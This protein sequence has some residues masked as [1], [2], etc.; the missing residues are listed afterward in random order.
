MLRCYHSCWC[1]HNTPLTLHDL[2]ALPS[3][4][5]RHILLPQEFKPKGYSPATMVAPN[6]L[7]GLLSYVDSQ[8]K[9]IYPVVGKRVFVAPQNVRNILGINLRTDGDG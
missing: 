2:F 1:L 6:W 7:V 9:T 8:A 4:N 3:T 5:T